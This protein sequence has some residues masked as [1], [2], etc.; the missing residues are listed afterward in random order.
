MGTYDLTAPRTFVVRDTL[1]ERR[2]PSAELATKLMR[3]D[4]ERRSAPFGSIVAGR[5]SWSV[6]AL[7][8]V[9]PDAKARVG[10]THPN[11]C[12]TSETRSSTADADAIGA[13]PG[14]VT[15]HIWSKVLSDND[16]S[17]G[18]VDTSAGRKL[19]TSVGAT[20]SLQ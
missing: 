7:M 11:G 4:A 10:I 2:L 5:L 13:M 17:S 19:V 3:H 9:S 1:D 15:V 6:N 12:W 18:S 20:T 16:C 14:R 8:F